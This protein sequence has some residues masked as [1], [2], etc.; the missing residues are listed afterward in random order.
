SEMR[1]AVL[2]LKRDY[3]TKEDIEYM[4]KAFENDNLTADETIKFKFVARV[5]LSEMPWQL[6]AWIRD[7]S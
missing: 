5:D 6:Y 1:E 7:G 4:T 2:F 3:F